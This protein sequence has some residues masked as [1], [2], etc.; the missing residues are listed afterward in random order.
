ML[1]LQ[2]YI[3]TVSELLMDLKW[4]R[5]PAATVGL[6]S[7]QLFAASSASATEGDIG[8]VYIDRVAVIAIA[9]GGHTAGNFEIQIK[10]GFS[11]PAGMN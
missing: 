9:S 8:P 6:I 10:G 1:A 5:W 7:A 3:T 4:I 2:G 11:V